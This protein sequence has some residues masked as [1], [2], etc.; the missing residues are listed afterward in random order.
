MT[1]KAPKDKASIWKSRFENRKSKMEK[2]F[3]DTQKYYDI[4]YA[5]QANPER[6]SPW[7]SKVYVPV[8]ASKAWDLIARMS[9]VVPL[10]DVTIKNELDL[11]DDGNFE[12]AQGVEDRQKR[13]EAKLHYDYTC[14]HDDPMK[15]RCLIR[16]LTL[17]SREQAMLTCH[18][19]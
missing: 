10:F 8:L 5:V 16:L 13:I 2:S 17:L 14:G 6:I 12:L 1:T 9:D 15:L 11:N 3:S 18:G 7:R 4:M 19:S